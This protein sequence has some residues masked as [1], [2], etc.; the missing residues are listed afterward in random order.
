MRSTPAHHIFNQYVIRVRAEDRDGLRDSLKD[1]RIGS[2]VYYP[3]PLHMQACFADL[4]YS[5][6]DFPH[7]ELAARQTIALPIY[8]ELQQEQLEAVVDRIVS[9]L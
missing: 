5:A 7:S 1:N 8:P 9:F 6:G 3:V 2:E 4:G